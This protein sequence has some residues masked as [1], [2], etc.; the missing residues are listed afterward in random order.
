MS[1]TRR[2][3]AV[4]GRSK[5]EGLHDRLRELKTQARSHTTDPEPDHAAFDFH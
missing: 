5:I 3:S 4:I 1:Q 2:L